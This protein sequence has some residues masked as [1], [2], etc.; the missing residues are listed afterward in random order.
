MALSGMEG[1]LMPETKAGSDDCGLFMTANFFSD[2]LGVAIGNRESLPTR[3]RALL[4]KTTQENVSKDAFLE[5]MRKGLRHP[6]NVGVREGNECFWWS[7]RRPRSC[8]WWS[9][10][11]T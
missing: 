4:Q 2:Y 10:E 8:G 3:L 5:A 11:K 1:F 7:Q 9:P 6:Q